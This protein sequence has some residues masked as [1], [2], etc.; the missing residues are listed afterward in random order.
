VFSLLSYGLALFVGLRLGAS[1]T[2]TLAEQLT[3]PSVTVARTASL[4]FNNLAS[5]LYFIKAAQYFG[6]AANGHDQYRYLGPLVE[7]VTELDPQF[8]EPLR[9]GSIAVQK[10]LGRDT[11]LNTAESTRLL[12]KGTLRFPDDYWFHLYLAYNLM[13]FDQNYLSAADELKRARVLPGAPDYV[14]P[15]IARVYSSAGHLDTAQGFA[16]A[17]ADQTDDPNLKAVMRD[18]AVDVQTERILQDLD[19]SADEYARRYGHRPQ[20]PSDLLAGGILSALPNE[21]RGGEWSIN[22]SDGTFRSS[23][24]LKRLRVFNQAIRNLDPHQIQ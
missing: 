16:E 20:S 14:A 9:W 8:R 19:R 12:K 7:L 24:L 13:V 17:L 15:L 23:K 2:K 10:N 4:G 5:D 1:D 3:L 6:A 22:S 11:W 18:R 21:P